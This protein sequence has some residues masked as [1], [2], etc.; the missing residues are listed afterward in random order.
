MSLPTKT[1]H[2]RLADGTLGITPQPT[3]EDGAASVDLR[4]GRWFATVR[5]TRTPLL[6]VVRRKDEDTGLLSRSLLKD[7]FIPFG[8]SFILHPGRFVLASTFEWISLPSDLMGLVLGKSSWARRGIDIE[9]APGIHPGFSGCLT[10]EIANSGAVP[11]EL[12]AGM[13]ICQI[14]LMECTGN[15]LPVESTHSN[16]RKPALGD[17]RFDQIVSQLQN[18]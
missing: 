16:Q 4:L 1:I 15:K 18:T 14:F 5:Y 6:S 9:K 7:R 13:K 12:V 2:D 17:I 8:A 3:M 11:V 10:L